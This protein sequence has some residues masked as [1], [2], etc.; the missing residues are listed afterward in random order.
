MM[1]TRERVLGALRQLRASQ[2][3]ETGITQVL[4]ESL[5]LLDVPA[6]REAIASPKKQERDAALD[7]VERNLD[8]LLSC[9][10]AQWQEAHD[11][12]ADTFYD[13]GMLWEEA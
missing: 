8:M 4:L 5:H 1:E 3:P 7:I 6:L 2:H 11:A 12:I 9:D 10:H 13:V